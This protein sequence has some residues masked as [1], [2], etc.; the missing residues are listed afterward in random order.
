MIPTIEM[1][2]RGYSG[3]ESSRKGCNRRVERPAIML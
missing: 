3:K 2:R 1:N